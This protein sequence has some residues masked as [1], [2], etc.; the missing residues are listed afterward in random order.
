MRISKELLDKCK[1]S[2]NAVNEYEINLS[3][4]YIMELNNLTITNNYYESIDLSNNNLVEL[5]KL[6][7]LSKL[8]TLNLSNNKID[9]IEAGFSE[10][11]PNLKNLILTNNLIIS[12]K[13]INNISSTYS[14]LRLSLSD[15]PVTKNPLYRS[16]TIFKIPSLKVLDFQKV[17]LN[18]KKQAKKFFSKLCEEDVEAVIKELNNK[19]KFEEEV[20]GVNK[21]LIKSMKNSLQN[22]ENKRKL[23]EKIKKTSNL[24]DLQLLEKNFKLIN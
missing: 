2:L 4:K 20:E 13:E 5:P 11:V 24:N 15:N 12:L 6:P 1:Q 8:Q 7:K 22:I 18:E 3:N 17:S 10:N 19:I 16:Y 23:I 9:T 14:L 21:D